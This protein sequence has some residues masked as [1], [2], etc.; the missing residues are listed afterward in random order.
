MAIFKLSTPPVLSGDYKEDYRK[1]DA[2]YR[3]LYESLWLEN[4]I[5]NQREKNLKSEVETENEETSI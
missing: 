1:L 5:K 3:E 2:W 4:F